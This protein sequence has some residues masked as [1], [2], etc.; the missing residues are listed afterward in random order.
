MS[1]N[2]RLQ[3]INVHVEY[4]GRI[5]TTEIPPYKPIEYLI[6]IVKNLFYPVT[7][8]IK[9]LYNQSDIIPYGKYIIGDFFKLKTHISLKIVSQNYNSD[10]P[11]F[12]IKNKFN[13]PN[14]NAAFMC[15]CGRNLISFYCR[16]SKAFICNYCRFNSIHEGHRTIKID[17]NNLI[18]NINKENNHNLYKKR[19]ISQENAK[20]LNYI[21]RIKHY[22]NKVSVSEV[23]QEISILNNKIKLGRKDILKKENEINVLKNKVKILSMELNK[24]KANMKYDKNLKKEFNKIK[25]EREQ[26]QKRLEESRKMR[27]YEIKK[28]QKFI[29][30]IRIKVKK[31]NEEVKNQLKSSIENNMRERLYEKRK[32]EKFIEEEKNREHSEKRKKILSIKQIFEEN[33]R[34]KLLIQMNKKQKIIDQ[35]RIQINEQALYN[36]NLEKKIKLYQNQGF[37]GIKNLERID[38]FTIY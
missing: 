9:I 31:H 38:T 21:E 17:T 28:K 11:H 24:K 1:I 36:K 22:K 12:Q 14:E 32:N 23:D 20:N 13:F 2:F 10:S 3:K 7:S 27:E 6:G 26:D 37:K 29:Q 34:K 4:L 8:K 15:S 25:K 18:N 30:N 16:T 35:L 19:S 5:K 33:N